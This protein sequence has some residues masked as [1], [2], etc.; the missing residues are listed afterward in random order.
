[1]NP[2]AITAAQMFGRLD[3]ATND[4]TDGIFSALWRKTLKLKA[5]NFFQYLFMQLLTTT[6]FILQPLPRCLQLP[7]LS[8]LKSTPNTTHNQILLYPCR[9][10]IR[11]VGPGR[12][13]RQH[14]DRESQFRLGRQQNP[15]SG[16]RR[17]SFHG[18]HLQDH[19]RA[20]KHRQR[21]P[22][23]RLQKRNGLH[24]LFW[25]KL[26]T[27]RQSLAE[28]SKR[29]GTRSFSETVRRVF[30]TSLCVGDA[31]FETGHGGASM[32]HYSTIAPIA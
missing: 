1:M 24:E 20:R 30:W 15:D 28:E 8:Y 32:Q 19:L 13:G 18:T 7:G 14:L 16:Q 11:V 22:C 12:S 3:V 9:R 23:H 6:M 31:E 29:K 25:T 10:R 17:S 5:G 4:W 2:K 26:E 27:C 21:L